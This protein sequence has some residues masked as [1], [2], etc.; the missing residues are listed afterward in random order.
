MAIVR[1]VIRKKP[2]L[3]IAFL[4]FLFLTSFGMMNIVVGVIVDT[5][6]TASKEDSD[7]MLRQLLE[8]RSKAVQ[9]LRDLFVKSDLDSDGHLSYA[10]FLQCCDLKQVQDTLEGLDLPV[11]RA[12]ELFEILDVHEHGSLH[13]DEFINGCLELHRVAKSNDI[14]GLVLDCKATRRKLDSIQAVLSTIHQE[15]PTSEKQLVDVLRDAFTTNCLA[16]PGRLKRLELETTIHGTQVRHKLESLGIVAPDEKL[17]NMYDLMDASGEGDID[18]E[19]FIQ[20]IIKRWHKASDPAMSPVPSNSVSAVASL[21]RR[22]DACDAQGKWLQRSHACMHE[23]LGSL[24]AKQG[25]PVPSWPEPLNG[26]PQ[27]DHMQAL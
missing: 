23:A 15:E 10:E 17:R 25:L 9:E 24:L 6:L 14:M 22:V 2:F 3:A 11:A 16:T 13:V 27:R 21:S 1:P 12:A 4:L 18:V 19:F 7:K 26:S 5:T 20:R 8:H